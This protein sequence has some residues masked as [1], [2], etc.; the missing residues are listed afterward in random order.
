[1]AGRR[2]NLTRKFICHL[3]L[4]STAFIVNPQSEPVQISSGR[5]GHRWALRGMGPTEHVGRAEYPASAG[6]NTRHAAGGGI[7]G[8]SEDENHRGRHCSSRPLGGKESRI[9]RDE[10]TLPLGAGKETHRE[11]VGHPAIWWARHSPVCSTPNGCWIPT[12]L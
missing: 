9:S 5:S 4:L 2:G 7:V 6:L 1:V 12:M 10:D 3:R 11:A 8:S